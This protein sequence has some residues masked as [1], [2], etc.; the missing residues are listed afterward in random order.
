[1]GRPI[2]G[3]IVACVVFLLISG[4]DRATAQFTQLS[5][6]LP[7]ATDLPGSLRVVDEGSRSASEIVASFPDPVEAA[8][9]FSSWG[10][11]ENSYRTYAQVDP[12]ASRGVTSLEV[13]LHRFADPT[14]AAS[15]LLYFADARAAALGL[16]VEPMGHLVGNVPGGTE[17]TVYDQQGTVLVRI[18]AVGPSPSAELVVPAAKIVVR[19]RL[20]AFRATEPSSPQFDQD[21]TLQ[22]AA[23]SA[24]ELSR[25]ESQ[26]DYDQLYDRL[27]PDAREVVPREA[28]IGWYRTEFGPRGPM[29]SSV[30]G[31]T[32]VPWTWGVTGTTYAETAQVVYRQR[33]ADGSEDRG[34]VH[35][36]RNDDGDWGWFFG[37]SRAW[38][39]AQVAKYAP[40]PDTPSPA[41]TAV[42]VESDPGINEIEAELQSMR[43]A[44]AG[45]ERE[46]DRV[47]VLETQVAG[48]STEV[49]GLRARVAALEEEPTPAV[50]DKQTDAETSQVAA[51]SPSP[52]P[53]PSPTQLPTPTPT[54]A[55]TPTAPPT[56]APTAT[57]AAI[58]TPTPT[59]IGEGTPY[60]PL[61]DVRELEV[62]PKGMIGRQI[63]FAGIVHS[64]DGIALDVGGQTADS[65]LGVVVEAGDRTHH[66]VAVRWHERASGISEG[67]EVEV[68]GT[69]VGLGTRENG[70][71]VQVPVPL[72]DADRVDLLRAGPEPNDYTP[73]DQPRPDSIDESLD[74]LRLAGQ[75][76]EFT[77]QV[78]NIVDAGGRQGAG[79]YTDGTYSTVL[80]VQVLGPDDILIDGNLASAQFF[81]VATNLEVTGIYDESW[82][83]VR[84]TVIDKDSYY[85]RDLVILSA[86]LVR[87][88]KIEVLPGPPAGTRDLMA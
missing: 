41:E 68:S 71:G 13:S 9:Q 14:G 37:G 42:P 29:V 43:T 72:I 85:N 69:F 46:G 31:V 8:Q 76:I 74:D 82:L 21:P 26:A 32:I 39:D 79:D 40:L 22:S 48:L 50:L 64:T 83:R 58:A 23:A 19:Q 20:A 4:L 6:G 87:A 70:N 35:L 38:L 15:A 55:P 11:I 53:A 56:I 27:H 25:L 61:G 52:T 65:D 66:A 18:T 59:A 28:V 75:R 78:V 10:W 49:A 60:Q 51:T 47:S 81:N 17:A 45:L 57:P 84:G 73:Y 5:N 44:V 67:A 24:V 12:P 63:R 86:P 30:E 34:A 3:A 16:T 62:R 77:C 1:M 80:Q 33:F 2:L 7:A 36:V 54:A 88:E